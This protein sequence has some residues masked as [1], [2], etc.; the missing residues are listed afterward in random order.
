MNTENWPIFYSE[1]GHGNKFERISSNLNFEWT[2]FEFSENRKQF[3]S[4]CSNFELTA[5]SIKRA[6]DISSFH[7]VP[8]GPLGPLGA[9]YVPILL[10]EV[11]ACSVGAGLCDGEGKRAYTG[12]AR[13]KN[14]NL[15]SRNYSIRIYSTSSNSNF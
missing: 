14:S 11:E 5:V 3:E 6:S 8:R 2:K 4:L 13:Y 7:L 10:S 12:Y 15:V 1:L 9:P